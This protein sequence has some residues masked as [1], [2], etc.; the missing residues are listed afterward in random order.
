MELLN[1][2]LIGLAY[3][4]LFLF[5]ILL[6]K[7]IRELFTRFDIVQ[8]LVIN[9]NVAFSISYGGYL[10]A[11][12][13]I[14]IGACSGP[15]T[16]LLFDL[17]VVLGYTALGILMLN[18]SVILNDKFI[19][20]RFS[21][22]KA[23]IK[24]RNIGVGFVQLG[25]YLASGLMIAGSIYGEDGNIALTFALFFM[26]QITLILYGLFYEWLT[27]YDTQNEIQQGNV[28]AGIAFAGAMLG[29]GIIL[30][31]GAMTPIP[32]FFEHLFYFVFCICIVFL[33]LPVI[34]FVLDKIIIPESNINHEIKNDHNGGAAFL[35]LIISV[36]FSSI[37]F[38]LL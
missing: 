21:N 1:G 7:W 24:D 2:L 12:S 27:P 32:S 11:T 22:I 31:K 18:I 10:L 15:H 30:L 8:E 38:L 36:S 3:I 35:E 34:R 28:S 14:F 16:Y 6:A 5:C 9:D 23:I 26:G 19:L 29:A 17:A 4:A 20:H 25:S 37:L 13:I 33:S